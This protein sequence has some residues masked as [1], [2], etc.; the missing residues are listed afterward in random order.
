[1]SGKKREGERA[2][3]PGEETS[4]TAAQQPSSPADQQDQDQAWQSRPW[5][6]S[7]CGPQWRGMSTGLTGPTVQARERE[8]TSN[9]EATHIVAVFSRADRSPCAY[10]CTY[11]S[12]SGLGAGRLAGSGWLW[13]ASCPGCP[14][15][16]SSGRVP[17]Y[18]TCA[19]FAVSSR[20]AQSLCCSRPSLTIQRP[21][22]ARDAWGTGPA[23]GS[24]W[25]CNQSGRNPA[26]EKR[27]KGWTNRE[28]CW[29]GLFVCVCAG[30]HVV[31]PLEGGRAQGADASAQPPDPGLHKPAS[32]RIPGY[33]SH[34]HP[35]HLFLIPD[36]GIMYGVLRAAYL[37][38]AQRNHV[39]SYVILVCTRAGS[40]FCEPA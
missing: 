30:Q 26:L 24:Y 16:Q 9:K 18:C 12:G 34:E 3:G 14:P 25:S 6:E 27:G 2:G 15:L 4:G 35:E 36:L 7:A 5:L 10:T 39:L 37:Y 22:A 29:R 8:I 13:L 23:A 40:I 11:V 31:V 28:P 38:L 33:R 1:M 21:I 32:Q 19:F 17:R 20:I